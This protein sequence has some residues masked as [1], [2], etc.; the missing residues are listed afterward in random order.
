M[1]PPGK[2]TLIKN[3]ILTIGNSRKQFMVADE[4]ELYA[5]I[6]GKRLHRYYFFIRQAAIKLSTFEKFSSIVKALEYVK[7]K[8]PVPLLE[9]TYTHGQNL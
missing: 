5:E 1:K 4:R 7:E 8:Y 6:D 2:T 3:G 9:T